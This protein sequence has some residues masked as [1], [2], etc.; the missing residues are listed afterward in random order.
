MPAVMDE[1]EEKNYVKN[2]ADDGCL[3][4][5]GDSG[6]FDGEHVG[7]IEPGANEKICGD[8]AGKKFGEFLKM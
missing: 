5:E 8:D 3:R 6:K 4:C 1:K 7:E 2:H